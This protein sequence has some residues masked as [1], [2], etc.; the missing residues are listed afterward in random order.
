MMD[1]VC[2]IVLRPQIIL[3]C[4]EDPFIAYEVHNVK[5]KQ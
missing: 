2:Q 3:S 5:I 4:I 1:D